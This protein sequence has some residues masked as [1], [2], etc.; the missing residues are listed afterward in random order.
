MK[1]KF[2]LPLI[3][4]A[5]FT[6]NANAQCGSKSNNHHAKQTS[7]NW[8]EHH[9]DIVDIA[10]DSDQFA[11]LVVALKTADLVSTLQSDGPFTVFAPGNAAFAKL[12]EGTVESLLQPK[13]KE[14]LTKILTYHVVA[15]DFKAKDVITAIKSSGGKFTIETVSGDELVASMRGETLILTDEKGNNVAVTNADIE[16]SN[17]VIHVIDSVVLPG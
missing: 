1:I 10:S 14:T 5:M 11:T 7:Y 13:N 6:L 8:N 12:P 9:R 15:G 17:G 3:A 16:A 2:I 4:L